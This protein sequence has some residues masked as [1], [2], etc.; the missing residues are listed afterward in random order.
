M[1]ALEKNAGEV[2]GPALDWALTKRLLLRA[3]AQWGDLGLAALLL[4]L[5][6]AGIQVQPLLVGLL[7]DYCQRGDMAGARPLFMVLAACLA[8]VFCLQTVE[9]LQTKRLGLD[10]SLDLR[11][12]LFH[13]IHT[14]SLRYFDKNPVGSLMTRVIYDVE[15]LDDFFTAGVTAVFQD[16]FTVGLIA[17]FLVQMDWRLGLA[18]L[19]LVPLLLWSTAIFRREARVNFRALRKNNAA[20]NAFLTENLVGMSTV[21]AHNR[22]ERNA[23]KF[24]A[25]NRDSLG[26]L[27]EQIRIN[28]F[29]MPLVELLAAASLGVVIWYGGL[30][31]F[32]TGLS[33][34]VVVAATL[35]IQ[36]LYEPLRDLTD[37]FGTFQ[38]AMASSERVF[39]LLDLDPDVSDP[40][41]PLPARAI[42]GD[43]E[44]RD[45][46]FAYEPGRPALRDVSFRVRPGER[47]AVVGPTG[48]GKTSLV[49]VLLRFYPIQSGSVLLDGKPLEAYARAE[50]LRHF[51]LVPQDPFLFSGPILENLRLS[52]ASVPRERVVWACRQ[53]RAD[54]FIDTM[55]KGYDTELAEGGSNLSTGQKQLLSFARALVFDPAVLILDEATASVDT[56]T[57]AEIQQALA[58]LLEGRSSLTIAHRLSTVREADRILVLKDG[59][60]AE[61]GSHAEL[62]EAGGLYKGLIE[63]QFKE[64]A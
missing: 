31:H 23:T 39:A 14:Q 33:L 35:Y 60:L 15:T 4:L 47:V 11:Q 16:I 18:A 26:I 3:R 37:K 1:P 34:G 29:F 17:F 54:A 62:M 49:N 52:D 64:R 43:V 20:M 27:L 57:E 8:W 50:Y 40:A 22:Q 10:L 55:P 56:A 12:S 6:S 48:S 41:A 5:V 28:A 19:A 51:A 36:R 9:T 2:E 32:G 45:V 59:R 13:K 25:I 7:L 58:V 53:V 61:Q 63:L 44:F 24:D 38:S 42:R 30:R 21:Q 46:T